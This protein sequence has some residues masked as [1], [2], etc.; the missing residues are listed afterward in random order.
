MLPSNYRQIIE[1]ADF[2]YSSLGKAFETQTKATEEQGE[3]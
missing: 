3:K 2:A 1:Q